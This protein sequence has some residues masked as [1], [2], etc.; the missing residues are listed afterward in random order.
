[1]ADDVGGAVGVGGDEAV[2]GGLL[3]PAS[4][5]RGLAGVLL[6]VVVVQDVALLVLAVGSET[7]DKAV[8]RSL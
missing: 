5:S 7:L 1:M 3:V 4:L 6:G 2:V 8:G